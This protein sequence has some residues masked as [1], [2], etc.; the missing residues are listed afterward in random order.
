MVDKTARPWHSQ[1]KLGTYRFFNVNNGVEEIGG[2]NSHSYVNRAEC[3]IAAAL[4]NRL[5]REFTTF[6]FDFKVGVISMYRG[7]IF[8]MRRA[9]EK[10]FG[11]TISGTV[12]F[13]TVDGFQGQEKDVII[14][15][16][17]RAGPGVQSVGFLKGKI[18][19]LWLQPKT[20]SRFSECRY[21]ADECSS[22]TRK[23][24]SVCAW[25]CAYTR[26]E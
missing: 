18:H 26:A 5:R 10:M 21:K 9:F 20:N 1:A 25:A 11:Q 23:V 3:Q 2:G 24:I 13:N 8:E 4:Y 6:D 17:V 16:C 22:H 19:I 15:S 14:L 7:Q 12:D